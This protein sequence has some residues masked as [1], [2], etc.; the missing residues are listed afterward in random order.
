MVAQRK[1]GDFI[2]FARHSMDEGYDV[3]LRKHYEI[4]GVAALERLWREHLATAK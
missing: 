4:D 1:P 2:A 3:A